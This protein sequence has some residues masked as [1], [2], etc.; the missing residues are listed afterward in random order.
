VAGLE[1]LDGHIQ[2][3]DGFPLTRPRREEDQVAGFKL[4]EQVARAVGR[5]VSARESAG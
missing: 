2:R 5:G 1:C 4:C 3:E